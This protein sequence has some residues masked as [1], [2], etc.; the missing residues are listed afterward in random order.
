MDE[1]SGPAFLQYLQTEVAKAK[2]GGITAPVVDILG[3]LPAPAGYLIRTGYYLTA[4]YA[5][6]LLSGYDTPH[7]RCSEPLE[8]LSALYNGELRPVLAPAGDLGRHIPYKRTSFGAE[9]LE[10]KGAGA[11]KSFAAILSVKEYPPHAQPGMTDALLRLPYEM[12]L[13]ESFAFVDRQIGR[14]SCRER[15]S[16]VV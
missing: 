9:A 11:E 3:C 1:M 16:S 7:G 4:T 12:A 14:A 8:M 5:P 15:V 6:R 2:T 13:S 10:Q